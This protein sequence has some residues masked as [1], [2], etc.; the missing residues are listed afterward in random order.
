MKRLHISFVI[1]LVLVSTTVPAVAQE[2]SKK[3]P[4]IVVPGG[5]FGDFVHGTLVRKLPTGKLLI[6]V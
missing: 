4:D 1:L 5:R 2:R 3:F 6:T